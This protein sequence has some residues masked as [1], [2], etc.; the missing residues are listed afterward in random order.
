MDL[1][2]GDIETQCINAAV[3]KFPYPFHLCPSDL[4]HDLILKTTEGSL[5]YTHQIILQIRANRFWNYLLQNEVSDLIPIEI[6]CSE[7]CLKK[8]LEY[9][10][11]DTISVDNHSSSLLVE[12]RNWALKFCVFRLAAICGYFIAL[13]DEMPIYDYLPAT[14]PS[15]FKTELQKV[16][17]F[18]PTMNQGK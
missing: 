15:T 3:V 8:F 12:L 6:S 5:V 9:C 13:Q 4:H 16:S 18:L 11:T 10:Y 14:H 1:S 7:W 2:I 17:G